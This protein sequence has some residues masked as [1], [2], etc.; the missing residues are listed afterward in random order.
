[1]KTFKINQVR[2]IVAVAIVAVL[3][4]VTYITNPA[5]LKAPHA[6]A[7]AG[8]NVSGYA[9]S[10][11]IGWISFNNTGDGSTTSY[12]VNVD[13]ANKA[14]GGTGDF[15]GYAW[16]ENV[17]WISFSASD[18]TGC[19]S[20]TCKAQVDWSTGKVTGWAR[21][22]S[23]VGSASGWD[24]WIKL[25]D[26]TVGVWAGKGVKISANKFSGYAWG[27]GDGTGVAGVIG[28]VDFAPLIGTV[29][30]GPVLGA[31]PCTPADV[32]ASGT[33]GTCQALSSCTAPPATQT[34][35]GVRVGI[36]VGGST[37]VQS[38]SKTITCQE[39][40]APTAGCNNN[41]VCD[42]GET[43]LTCPNDCKAKYQQ[44]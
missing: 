28:W 8:E 18:L 11:N 29:P 5:F 1:M 15:S 10:E 44:F 37:T 13:I 3:V 43:L 27:G 36:C 22:L 26:D 23:A 35:A 42:T 7:G 19:P 16:S 6:E 30:V 12:G 41:N 14:T 9:W 17:G 34:V 31:P 25:S 24:G 33:W 39:V 32:D 2:N 21:S 38:C 4:G 20:G 40:T